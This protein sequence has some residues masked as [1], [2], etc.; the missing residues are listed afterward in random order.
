MRSRARGAAAAALA[1]LAALPAEADEL[2]PVEAG[3]SWVLAERD[4]DPRTGYAMYKRKP[5]G[6]DY[7]A[8]RL[9]SAIDA[10]PER[11]ARAAADVLADP[12]ARQDH[13]E[14]TI[15]RNDGGIILV[16]SYIHIAA[17]FVADRDVTTRAVRSF[18]AETGTH[19]LVWSASDEGPAPRDGV[20]RLE[21]SDGS[22]SFSRAPA[23]GTR[24]VYE[25]H[26][27]IAGSMPAWLVNVLMNDTMLQGLINLRERVEGGDSG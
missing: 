6:S 10:E 12:E 5:F 3:P 27:E 14:K 4:D 23:G 9:E 15:L 11:V 7:F 13:M 8:Y 2:P 1:S 25:S 21:K 17:P 26:T 18:E 24:V 16:Y 20:V 19:R 22:W